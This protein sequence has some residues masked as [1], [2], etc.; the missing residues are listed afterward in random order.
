MDALVP[1]QLALVEAPDLEVLVYPSD[2][3]LSGAAE[4]VAAARSAIADRLV[5]W[6]A[7]VATT[8]QGL[9]VED[10]LSRAASIREAERGEAFR[11]VDRR[12]A[13]IVIPTEEWDALVRKRLQL[14]RTTPRD[15]DQEPISLG[16][17]QRQETPSAPASVVRSA[18]S[19]RDTSPVQ[20]AVGIAIALLIAVDVLLTVIERR[21]PTIGTEP[22]AR[23]R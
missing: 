20:L 21:R 4:T 6:P 11:R 1:R 23:A 19:Q 10:E 17:R 8:P 12:L 13:S 18:V 22:T 7:H 14:E 5:E 15:A 3:A 9:S 2:I 16:E